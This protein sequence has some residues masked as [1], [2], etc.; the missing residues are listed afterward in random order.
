MASS[1]TGFSHHS[2][3]LI[4]GKWIIPT[5]VS[6]DSEFKLLWTAYEGRDRV[7]FLRGERGSRTSIPLDIFLR[8]VTRQIKSTCPAATP[9]Q[10]IRFYGYCN[11]VREQDFDLLKRILNF[12][13]E[14]KIISPGQHSS[15]RE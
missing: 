15:L 5:S 4:N 9:S 11:A 3:D 1:S 2:F 6:S 13:L 14:Y 10:A 8:L 12:L 7:R